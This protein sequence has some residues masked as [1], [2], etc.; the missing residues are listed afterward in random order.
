MQ[1]MWDSAKTIRFLKAHT[2]V[3]Q[4]KC[5]SVY[6]LIGHLLILFS[7]HKPNNINKWCEVFQDFEIANEKSWHRIL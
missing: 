1:E 5:M 4:V 2:H 6:H 7:K 3:I